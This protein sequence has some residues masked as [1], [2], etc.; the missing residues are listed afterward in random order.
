ML[1]V[2]SSL[3][4][5][6][7]LQFR[8]EAQA[9]G[10]AQAVRQWTKRGRVCR[11]PAV[12]IWAE[13]QQVSF[14]FLPAARHPGSIQLGG[15]MLPV[16]LTTQIQPLPGASLPHCYG[17]KLFLDVA[18]MQA[19]WKRTVEVQQQQPGVPERRLPGSAY[20]G[21]SEGRLWRELAALSREVQ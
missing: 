3:E 20:L 14:F 17:G 10:I 2:S 21:R 7:V 13:P 4:Q 16:C 6:K 5:H 15:G 12:Q 19:V 9:S 11:G 1:L 18:W 8:G